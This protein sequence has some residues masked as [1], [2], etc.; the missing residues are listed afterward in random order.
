MLG[1]GEREGRNHVRRPLIGMPVGRCAG[2]GEELVEDVEVAFA[3]RGVGEARALE[4]VVD[5]A[6][7]ADLARSGSV[8][9][10]KVQ[11]NE[12]AEAARVVVTLRLGVA[13]CLE[14]RVGTEHALT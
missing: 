7:A 1:G 6:C 11:L 4:Q 10:T 8:A 5:D 13:E 14:E 9:A 12:L 2:R 3:R